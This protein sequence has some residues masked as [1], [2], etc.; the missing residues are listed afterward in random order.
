MLPIQ[1]RAQ[2]RLT[3]E[4]ADY[5]LSLLLEHITGLNNAQQRI[6]TTP[7]SATQLTALEALIQ[8]RIAGE[9]IAYLLG[10]QPFY[11]ITL[12]VNTATLIPRP[13]TEILVE[14]AL[15]KI[16]AHSAWHIADLGTGSGAI[17]ISLAKHRPQAHLIAIDNSAAALAIAKQNAQDNHTNN[18]KFR[19]QHW[20]EGFAH[21]ALDMIVSNPPYIAADD[22][23]LLALHYE[24]Q[25]ALIA[26]NN[27]FADLQQIICAAE[28]VIKPQGWLLLE[29]GWQQG[30][31]LREFAQQRKAWQ[32]IQTRKDYGNNERVTLM[33]KST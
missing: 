26:A 10:Y 6:S 7:L 22:P 23:H 32:H 15:E 25:S 27:G 13:D 31:K 1:W 9:P 2:Q 33:Q 14:T 17:A 3:S 4:D 16:P 19:C 30:A 21:Q 8:R 24:P 20:L 11:D 12:R 5:E 28:N 18:I 29:H